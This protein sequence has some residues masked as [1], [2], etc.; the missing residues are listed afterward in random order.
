[1]FRVVGVFVRQKAT[2]RLESSR[3]KSLSYLPLRDNVELRITDE[4]MV[5]CSSR[6]YV[7]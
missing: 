6:V 3:R 1:M 7:S 2:V 4:F 5:S